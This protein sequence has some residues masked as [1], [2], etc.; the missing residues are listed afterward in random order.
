MNENGDNQG[1]GVSEDN[2]MPLWQHL[3]ELR[4]VLVKGLIAVGLVWL[5]TYYF[6]DR[7]GIVLQ[8]P[9][10][11][12][13]PESQRHLYFFGVAEKFMVYF[14]LSIVSAVGIVSPYLIYLAW[15]FVAPGLYKHEKKFLVPFLFFGSI[16]FVIGVLFGYFVVLPAC[17]RFL[18]NFGPNVI[19]PRVTLNQYFSL[20]LKLLLSLGIVFELPLLIVLLAKFGFV[21]SAML[22]KY[23]RH[24]ILLIAVLA[25]LISPNPDALTMVI[26][27]APLWLLFELSI[28]M[29]KWVAPGGK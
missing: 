27:M 2:R 14:K 8:Q 21:D 1:L 11:K 15:W 28:F 5:V 26:V 7:I 9:I 20:T 3:A 4:D 16:T 17:Y 12:V 13:L 19:E 24:A 18:I 29:V 25:A 23:R 10:L 22:S 6:C